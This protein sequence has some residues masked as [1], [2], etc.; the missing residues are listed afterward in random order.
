V[1]AT[2]LAALGVPEETRATF[3]PEFLEGMRARA[4]RL[5]DTGRAA[6]D[7]WE[8]GLGDRRGHVLLTVQAADL[9]AL[10]DRLSVLRDQLGVN[11]DALAVVHEQPAT[12]LQTQREHFGFGD[13]FAQPALDYEPADAPY[14]GLG[15][16]T[17]QDGW[18][19]L[20]T[21]ELL[22]GHE[23]EDG[24]LPAAPA[25]PFGYNGTYVVYRK[26]FQDVA[27]FRR[28]L[29]DA[30]E[31]YPGGM[32]KLAAKV[33][34]RWRDGTPLSLSP[35]TPDPRWRGANDFRYADDADGRRCPL[36]AHIRRA[37]PR[38]ALGH[39]GLLTM[40]H[41]IVRRGMPYG[42]ELPDD[43]PDDG[44]DRG[45]IFVCFAAHIARQFETIQTQW[46]NDGNA[47]GLGD[48][49]DYLLGDHRSTGKMTVHGD[50]PFFLSPLEPFVICRGGEYL[51]L[52]SMTGLRALAGTG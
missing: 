47:F 20:R 37:N 49:T 48:D 30:S 15:V 19:R 51:F 12:S 11:G 35:E 41:R 43:A 44:A 45:L 36:G 25:P 1:S 6:P 9:Q 7:N 38:D 29:Q 26:L 22:L 31:G 39:D 24:R 28:A 16:P 33:V 27:R 42:P 40:R 17:A 14:R 23:D 13:G 50:P 34:G 21:G 2:G 18:R 52:P 46:L 5:G 8:A 4:D 10:N 3:A 32:E